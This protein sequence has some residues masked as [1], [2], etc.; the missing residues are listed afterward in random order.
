MPEPYGYCRKHRKVV[1]YDDYCEDFEFKL[2][3]VCGNCEHYDPYAGVCELTSEELPEDDSGCEDFEPSYD[4]LMCLYC[5]HYEPPET[6]TMP[7]GGSPD[8]KIKIQVRCDVCGRLVTAEIVRKELDGHGHEIWIAKCPLC[9]RE[10]KAACIDVGRD[11]YVVPLSSQESLAESF[12]HLYKLL[13]HAKQILGHIEA[14]LKELEG[15]L[16]TFGVLMPDG[17]GKRPRWPRPPRKR[18]PKNWLLDEASEG[19]RRPTWVYWRK[20][21][22]TYWRVRSFV[23][24]AL[25]KNSLRSH[26]EYAR[27]K[28]ALCL[29]DVIHALRLPEANYARLQ[30]TAKR[31]VEDLV[32]LGVLRI[33]CVCGDR[34]IGFVLISRASQKSPQHVVLMPDR[35]GV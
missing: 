10:I 30:I 28:G 33:I 9:G 12:K 4:F 22:A 29:L 31:A 13:Q 16:R 23:I 17:A 19:P 20:R 2:P 34:E 14:R 1:C 26:C 6:K 25:E 18:L 3:E 11:E 15:E 27:E 35:R 24:E 8:I 5:T 7:D 21:N 32:E